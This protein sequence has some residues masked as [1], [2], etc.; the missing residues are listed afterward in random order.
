MSSPGVF[1]PPP[2]LPNI[3]YM[4]WKWGQAGWLELTLEKGKL[5]CGMLMITDILMVLTV[6]LFLRYD[7]ICKIFKFIP[8]NILLGYDFLVELEETSCESC[9]HKRYTLSVKEA[10]SFRG[11][12]SRI[13]W[14][15]WKKCIHASLNSP[16]QR[17]ATYNNIL[18]GREMQ[19][20]RG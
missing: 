19:V 18:W 6:Q 7:T 4:P 1:E 12:Y 16:S 8:S 13:L 3:L 10:E 5:W 9:V 14:R 11:I 15:S 2:P 20:K 17:H